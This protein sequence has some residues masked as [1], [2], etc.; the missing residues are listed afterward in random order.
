MHAS[1]LIESE[2]GAIK[3]YSHLKC[4]VALYVSSFKICFIYR[5]LLSHIECKM[6][7]KHPVE[8]N[9]SSAVH[10]CVY[11]RVVETVLFS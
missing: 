2:P 11:T 4:D 9:K 7:T 10:V 5:E 8:A 3:E 1:P 6:L